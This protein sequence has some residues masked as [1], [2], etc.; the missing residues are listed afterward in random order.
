ML[1]YLDGL[2]KLSGYDVSV[3][4]SESFDF[5]HIDTK[6]NAIMFELKSEHKKGCDLK[7]MICA[8][9]EMIYAQEITYEGFREEIHEK[10][11]DKSRQV[12]S[13][14]SFAFKHLKELEELKEDLE[15]QKIVSISD[16]SSK[17][18]ERE[19]QTCN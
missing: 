17:S 8:I 4:D 1:E 15:E 18:D 16:V 12:T 5:I 10:L 6:I 14:L 7:A 11:R 9:I 13:H 3:D 2:T 19:N